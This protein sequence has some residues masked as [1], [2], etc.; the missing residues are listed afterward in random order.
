MICTCCL[1]HLGNK[2]TR[3]CTP[4]AILHLSRGS[5][6]NKRSSWRRRS[7]RNKRMNGNIRL[8]N[9]DTTL[10]SGSIPE[11]K[12]RYRALWLRL[13]FETRQARAQ[14]IRIKVVLG[15]IWFRIK[16]SIW[17]HRYKRSR[18]GA[19]VQIFE[20]EGLFQFDAQHRGSFAITF[21]HF[22]LL[23]FHLLIRHIWL[24]SVRKRWNDCRDLSSRL[25]RAQKGDALTSQKRYDTH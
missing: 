18:S 20:L 16:E 12:S 13:Q 15:W 7:L 2:S 3:L 10:L 22:P 21:H 14:E 6:R 1:K 9:T 4:V 23:L 8:R 25:N 17:I 24:S 11:L 5:K 19:A